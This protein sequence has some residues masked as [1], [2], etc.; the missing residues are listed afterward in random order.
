MIQ[1]D[2]T[3]ARKFAVHLEGYEGLGGELVKNGDFSEIGA[4]VVENGAFN[5]LGT[6]VITN[7]D[8][9]ATPLG[10]EM[11]TFPSSDEAAGDHYRFNGYGTNII[12]YD[13][14]GVTTITYD[15]D[16]QGGYH[17]FN[18]NFNF[19]AP[20]ATI[21][22]NSYLA[23]I[24]C[25]VNSGTF[26]I[27]LSR[28]TGLYSELIATD[29]SNTDY[30]TYSVYFVAGV[31]DSSWVRCDDLGTGQVVSINNV[32]V[33]EDINLITN[34]D[35]SATGSELMANYDFASGLASWT[36]NFVTESGGVVTFDDVNA[37]IRQNET[38]AVGGSYKLV[39]E[40]D[41]D[42]KYRTGTLGDDATFI[43]VTLPATEYIVATANSTR[44][45]VYSAGSL[46]T[47][48]SVSV[49]E[50]GEDWS[51]L[52]GDIDSY[53]ENG[54]TITSLNGAAYNR[55][56]QNE[57]ITEDGKSYKVTYTIYATSYSTETNLRY[58]NGVSYAQFPEQGVGTYTFYFTR[59]GT[60]DY[61]YFYLDASASSS[62]TDTVTISSISVQELGEDWTQ[63][64]GWT[65]GDS[66]AISAQ[67]LGGEL[68]TN[69][70]FTATGADV[71][72]NGGFD[73]SIPLGD[74]GSGWGNPDGAAAYY[75]GG[76]KI[77]RGASGFARL[78]GADVLGND[79]IISISTSY[80][81]TYTV[82]ENNGAASV[83]FELAGTVSNDSA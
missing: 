82:L 43:T 19:A 50:L 9:T 41:G 14:S 8:F 48:S 64:Y 22:G 61:W 13:G 47:V 80:K 49:K 62:T 67:A 24:T 73:T 57:I 83:I 5:E 4:D 12:A 81:I 63:G 20:L 18:Y 16:V 30:V 72:Y 77:T 66:K 44:L 60:N 40:G 32:S 53:N 39:I 35:F 79:D 76:C 52:D 69:G 25:K 70:D 42:I 7:G 21:E 1:L 33:K 38:Y 17:Y 29:V 2:S 56:T 37:N 78:R 51:S 34:G 55:I 31:T 71:I 11:D 3:E 68:I 6:D 58:Y 74:T 28:G 36:N 45:Q 54:L 59:Q 15:N 27:R 10:S 26:S 46:A 65:I 23:T 75:L